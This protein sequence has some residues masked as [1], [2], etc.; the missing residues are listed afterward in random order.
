MDTRLRAAVDA[1]L[2][3]YDDVFALHRIATRVDDG[4]WTALGTPP[5]WH[6]AAKSVEPGIST[7]RVLRAV[8][9]HEHC[10]V[11]DSF[12]DL[13]L[14]R[15]GFDLLV[16]ATWLHHPA[17]EARPDGLPEGWSVVTTAES[18]AQWSAAHDYTGVLLPDVLDRSRFQVLARH[19]EDVLVGGAVLHRCSGVVGL[20]NA[21][22]AEGSEVRYDDLVAAAH[23]LQP[24]RAL[25]DYASGRDLDAMLE[26]GFTPLGPQRV[27]IR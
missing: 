9:A 19:D 25:T 12:G 23:A 10:A 21:W 1:S 2:C 4:L 16:E 22:A 3:W 7:E 13:D 11:A 6:S 20:S 27:W 26:S 8:E 24:G 5:P 15:H 17:L 18:L 14:E